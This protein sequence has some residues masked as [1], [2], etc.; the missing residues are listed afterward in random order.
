[1]IYYFC[2]GIEPTEENPNFEEV[3][4]GWAHVHFM[5]EAEGAEE[6]ARLRVESASWRI[7]KLHIATVG[8]ESDLP[9]LPIEIQSRLLDRGISLEVAVYQKGGG[10]EIAGDPF[11]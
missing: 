4:A 9:A 1:M 11:E 3:Q 2:F 8:D 6:K 5:G 10:P 7:Q